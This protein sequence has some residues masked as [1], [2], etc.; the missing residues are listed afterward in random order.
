[1]GGEPPQKSTFGVE[2][3]TA[4]SDLPMADT[5]QLPKARGAFLTPVGGE[6]E[7]VP[8]NGDPD[9]APEHPH[10]ALERLRLHDWDFPESDDGAI[11]SLHP[12]PAKFISSIPRALITSL[13]VAP[14]TAVLDPFCGAGTTLVVAQELC[15]PSIGIDLNPIACLISR[16]KTTPLP[17]GL[18]Q[19]A[20]RAAAAAHPDLAGVPDIPNVKHWFSEQARAS[21]ASL[22]V[23]I[24]AERDDAVRDHLRLALSTIIVRV[25]NQESDT[26][27]AAVDKPISARSVRQRFLAACMRIEEAKR[28]RD[29]AGAPA[30]VVESDILTVTPELIGRE[31]SLVVT[32]PPYPNAYEYWLYH[33]YRM[34]WLGYD[35]IA[36]KEREIGARAHYFRKQHATFEDFRAQMARVLA[37]LDTVLIPEG[38]ACFIL[39]RS[40]IHG[41]DYDNAGMIAEEAQRIGFSE[42]ARFPRVI[43][44]KRK[45]FN[46]SHARIKTEEVLV[47]RKS[48]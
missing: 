47:L 9:L 24:D 8:P 29:I 23:Q 38:Y 19:A 42:A 16:I 25:S 5:L 32:S 22:V 31:I 27:Y 39:G 45:S 36:V 44:A 14:G 20:V 33:K 34:W 37:L 35:P 41:V 2:S 11:H 15:I 3:S 48:S 30:R 6:P 4:H 43:R 10:L 7:S 40:R 12:Y 21:L 26:R 18:M 46:L 13:G 1:M 28:E 17:A